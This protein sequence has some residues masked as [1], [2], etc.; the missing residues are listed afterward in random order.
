MLSAFVLFLFI[1]FHYSKWVFIIRTVTVEPEVCSFPG[2]LNYKIVVIFYPWLSFL[3][4]FFGGIPEGNSRHAKEN[5][6]KRI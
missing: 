3:V 2:D 1:Q 6:G 5:A 4:E